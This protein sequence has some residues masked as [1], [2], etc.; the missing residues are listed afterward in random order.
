MKQLVEAANAMKLTRRNLTGQK[1]LSTVT[2]LAQRIRLEGAHEGLYEAAD[3]QWWW[4]KGDAP[5]PER[6]IFWFDASDNAVACLV[7]FDA[8]D[9]WDNDFLWLPSARRVVEKQVIPEVVAAI[10][11]PD[12][13]SK[14]Y[15]RADDVVL[16]KAIEDAGFVKRS[17]ALVITELVSD[18]ARTQLP[19]GFHLTSRV[20]DSSPHHL[21]RRNGEGIAVKLNECSLYRPELDLCIRDADGN[22][23]AYALFWMDDVTKVGLLEPLRTEAAFQRLGLARHLIAEGV[24]RLRALGAES[25]RVAYSPDNEAAARLYHQSGFADRIT[26]LEYSRDPSQ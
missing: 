23:A 24:T 25:I 1:Y 3:F 12:K 16:L 5:F 17:D 11:T 19:P 20:E 10:T 21:M 15:L 2:D 8:G 18:P 4:R 14:I 13:L 7:R 26:C 9:E 6:Q 22:V